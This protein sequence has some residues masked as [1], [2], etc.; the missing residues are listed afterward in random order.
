MVWIPASAGLPTFPAPPRYSVSPTAFPFLAL[1]SILTITLR[2]SLLIM[3]HIWNSSLSS[4]AYA[5]R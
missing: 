2:K 3:M 4:G 5:L 1:T